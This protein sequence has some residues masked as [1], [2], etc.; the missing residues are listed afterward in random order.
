ME[1][2]R[3][4]RKIAELMTTFGVRLD[5]VE[6]ERAPRALEALLED[7]LVRFDGETLTV[8]TDGRA[9]LRNTAAFF[10]EYLGREK[11]SGP[12]YSNSV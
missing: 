6:R 4:R 12:T 5:P 11:A 10:D 9:F 2:R 8:P 3:R 1:D 7:G